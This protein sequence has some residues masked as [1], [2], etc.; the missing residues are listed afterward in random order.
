MGY[1]FGVVAIAAGFFVIWK[2]QW[3]LEQFGEIVWAEAKFSGGTRSFWKLAGLG[4][5]AFSFL[6]MAGVIHRVLLFIFVP[7]GL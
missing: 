4:L 5:I 2:T 1:V 7:G 6:A 3:M